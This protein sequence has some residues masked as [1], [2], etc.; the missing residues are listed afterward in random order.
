MKQKKTVIAAVGL[1]L[2]LVVSACGSSKSATGSGSS[3]TAGSGAASGTPYQVGFDSS[4]SGPYAANGVGQR[5]GFT[6][7]INYINNHGGVNGHPIHD[8]AEFRSY[9]LHVSPHEPLVLQVE[10]MGDLKFIPITTSD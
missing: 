9:L 5:G 7:Y 8:A 4:L 3:T 1:S 6:A 2:A 10:R